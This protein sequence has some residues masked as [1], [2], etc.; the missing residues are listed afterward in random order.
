VGAGVGVETEFWSFVCSSQIFPSILASSFVLVALSRDLSSSSFS[1][2]SK[3][4][5]FEFF[6]SGLFLKYPVN[7][8]LTAVFGFKKWSLDE[9]FELNFWLSDLLD[10]SPSAFRTFF[11]RLEMLCLL[12][13]D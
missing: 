5:C 12:M 4:C 6:N 2:T 8:L 9:L 7:S 13:L 11:R 3:L 1:A 10:D